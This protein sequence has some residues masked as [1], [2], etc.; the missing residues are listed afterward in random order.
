MNCKIWKKAPS[1]KICEL[2]LTPKSSNVADSSS[3]INALFWKKWLLIINLKLLMHQCITQTRE[4]LGWALLFKG[5]C[6]FSTLTVLSQ[7]GRADVDFGMTMWL[8][9]KL[10]FLDW[11]NSA[12]TIAP[13]HSCT[14]N[15][16]EVFSECVICQR[17]HQ[18]HCFLIQMIRR[19]L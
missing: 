5:Q 19:R 18:C 15:Q 17:H 11:V 6:Q 12:L 7:V 4:T 2:F 3:I 1:I 13:M 14:I 9:L 10:D 8:E 16:S